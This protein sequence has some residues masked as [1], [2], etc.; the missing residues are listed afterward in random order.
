MS[1]RSLLAVA[2]VACLPHLGLGQVLFEQPP[3]SPAGLATS[4]WWEPDDS[5][6]DIHCWDSFILPSGGTIEEVRW[7][8][9][10]EY[11][12]QYG[13]VT[14]FVI[15]FY[16][17]NSYGGEPDILAEPVEYGVRGLAGERY[18]GTFN[19]IQM[20]EYSMT[21]DP[22]FVAE[23]GVKYWIKILGSKTNIP[24]WGIAWGTGGNGA[25]FRWIRGYHQYFSYPHDLAFTLLGTSACDAD[26]NADGSVNTLDVLAFLN[27]WSA[28]EP[29]ADFNHDGT[30]NTLDVL[31][32]LN[33]WSAGC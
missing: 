2:I 25:H 7:R 12:G 9:G 21:I 5:D 1:L 17:S 11:G 33:A 32:F 13:K 30:I 6:Y 10:Y 22:G 8:G 4:C 31:G 28:G 29:T 24:D 19:G 23:P 26:F 14:G 16:P 27:A 15:G 20:F 3:Q 18:V